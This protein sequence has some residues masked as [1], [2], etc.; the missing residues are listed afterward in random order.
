MTERIRTVMRW[1]MAAFYIVAGAGHLLRPD[2]FLPIVPDWVP[3]PREMILATGV[4]ELAGAVALLTVRL[5]TLAGVML[6]LYALCVWPANIKHAIEGVH[7]PPI[8]D[9]WWYHGPRLAFQPVLIWWALF[10]AGV[11]DWPR[12][13][14]AP[15]D[16]KSL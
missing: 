11:I 7:L 6:A 14:A 13:R 1:T 12:G 9:S 4:C 8:P 10:C 15:R 5:R 2:A 16:R 3:F